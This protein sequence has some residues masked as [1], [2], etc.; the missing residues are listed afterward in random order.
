MS[1]RLP[2]SAAL[3]AFALAG[4]T[5]M[6]DLPDRRI[7]SA[8]IS[9]PNGQPVGTAQFAQV[10]NTAT[11]A[12]ALTGIAPG[13][14]GI[15]LHTTGACAAPDFTSAAGHLNPLDRKHGSA[16]PGG[17][18]EG[19]LPNIVIGSG[20]S[21]TL[22]ADLMGTPDQV[23]SWL[24]DADGTAIVVHAAPDDYVTDPSG[25]SG[26]RIACGVVKPA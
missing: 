12:V 25:N 2:T 24:F 3:L 10:G 22:T 19:D 18:H 15:H 7:G 6:A 11:V 9:L 26:A 20:G 5:T 1:P 13:T 8:T 16:A 21:G 4:C 17:K 14:H 23:R